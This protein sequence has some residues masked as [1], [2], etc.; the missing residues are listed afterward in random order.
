MDKKTGDLSKGRNEQ[1][2]FILPDVGGTS[3]QKQPQRYARVL[4]RQEVGKT[5]EKIKESLVLAYLAYNLGFANIP[6]K[7]FMDGF[8]KKMLLTCLHLTRGNQKDAATVLGIKPTVLFEKM[9]KHGI[10]RQQVKIPRELASQLLERAEQ[11]WTGLDL[12]FPILDAAGF[13]KK[14]RGV[15]R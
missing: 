10:S 6:L 11:D 4:P 3:A 9:R 13:R 5:L 12:C 15:P 1:A 14:Q 7:D 8:E 2:L